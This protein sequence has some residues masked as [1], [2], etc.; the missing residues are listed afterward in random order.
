M[1]RAERPFGASP[2]RVDGALEQRLRRE[3]GQ[4]RLFRGLP[5]ESVA[6]DERDGGVPG[7]DRDGKVEAGDD[8]DD[9]ERMP[10]LHHAMAG[11]L[12]GDG[13]AVELAR[14]ADGVVANVDHLL[15]F[16]ARLGDDLAGLDA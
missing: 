1:T 11:S 16:A 7:P 9:A 2:K 13:E 15:H 4:R 14:Q 8:A 6:A 12:G 3:R 5:D 10:C